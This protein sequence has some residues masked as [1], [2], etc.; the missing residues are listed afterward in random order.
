M[1]TA[2]DTS[3]GLALLHGAAEQLWVAAQQWCPALSIE[4]LPEVD[5]TNTHL[6][7]QGKDALRAGNTLHPSVAVAWSQTAGRGRHGRLWQ[8]QP[9]HSLTLSLGYP[10]RVDWSVPGTSALSLAAGVA[11]CEALTQAMPTL[12]VQLKWPNDLWVGG[13]KLGGILIEVAHPTTP[14]VSSWL[15]LGLGLNLAGVPANW[16]H[17]RCDLHS[18]GVNTHPGAAMGWVVPA[19]VQ[20]LQTFEQQGF[21]PFHARYDHFDA[22]KGRGVRLWRSVTA[23][24][25]HDDSQALAMG[26]ALGVDALGALLVRDAAGHVGAWPQGEVTVRAGG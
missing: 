20:A 25:L 15:V 12:P 14:G 6:M 10:M 7:K 11:V 1:V 19:L 3:Q 8:A 22:L 2:P 23:E 21:A 9:G 26:T 24:H 4:V 18:L 17:E 16:A 13:R 5:S